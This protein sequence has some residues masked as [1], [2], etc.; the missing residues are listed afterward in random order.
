MVDI[1]TADIEADMLLQVHDDLVFEVSKDKVKQVVPQN[2]T[3]NGK[4][5]FDGCTF[6]SRC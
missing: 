2:K 4:Y 1:Y 6:I 3:N 5:H